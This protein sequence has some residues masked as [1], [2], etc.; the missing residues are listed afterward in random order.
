MDGLNEWGAYRHR[1]VGSWDR[2]CL[3]GCGNDCGSARLCLGHWPRRNVV[4]ECND[5]VR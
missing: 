5:M 2:T 4:D 3:G 1:R